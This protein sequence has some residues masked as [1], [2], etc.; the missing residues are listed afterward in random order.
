M[1]KIFDENNYSHLHIV[2]VGGVSTSAL[3]EY[4][5]ARG[6][7]VSGSDESFNDRCFRLKNLG[8]KI[9]IG[10]RAKNITFSKGAL[11]Y[12]SAVKD[13]NP[14]IVTARKKG[15]DIFKRSEV[16]GSVASKYKNSIAVSGSHGKTTTSCMIADIF[17]RANLLPTIFLGG[18]SVNFN[19]FKFAT[20]DY[21]V[22]EA[23]EYDRSF[24]DFSP[25]L[26]V[27][28]NVDNDHLDTYQNIT[29]EL[30]AFRDFSKNSQSV[31]CVDDK[32]AKSL[33]KDGD[34][35]FGFSK[36]ARYR[37]KYFKNEEDG[38]SFSVYCEKD[39]LGRVKLNAIGRYNA[40]NALSAIAVSVTCGIDFAV[41]KD[42]LQ[43]FK[44]VKRR[45][46]FLGEKDGV[47]IY[48]DYAHHPSEIKA[49]YEGQ[50]VD[51]LI[52][53]QPHTYSRTKLL[54]SD[55]ISVLSKIENLII[56]KT[57]P[58]REKYDKTGDALT[59]YKKIKKEKKNV[60][61]AKNYKKLHKIILKRYK[62]IEKIVFM[63]A[64]DIYALAKKFLVL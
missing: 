24:L 4:F 39:R 42:A 59:L 6:I 57:Y 37:A 31:V 56:Y 22:Y 41:I 12:T 11:I 29:E 45:N 58:A 60:R 55:F 47:K 9:Y 2:G 30:S 25:T 36:N 8:A 28:L 38:I 44:G 40:L 23:C 13:N 34:I 46:E 43:N 33:V 26:S 48:S 32:Y 7:F 61:Y 51:T 10:H 50:K 19:N 64:G 21:V 52:V 54:I 17:M 5:L 27:V 18:E 63:G 35:T 53:F 20:G 49:V 15:L 14:E 62:G 3:A 16:L 1:K